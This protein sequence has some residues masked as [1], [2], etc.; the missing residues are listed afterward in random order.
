[1]VKIYGKKYKVCATPDT[2][3]LENTPV[4]RIRPKHTTTVWDIVEGKTYSTKQ[5]RSICRSLKMNRL[6]TREIKLSLVKKLSKCKGSSKKPYKDARKKKH[7]PFGNC[8]ICSNP[9]NCK[10]HLF[11]LQH[12][13]YAKEWN[14]INICDYCHAE[15][16]PWLPKP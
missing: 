15:V 11:Q 13:G 10:H 5:S 8:F 9:A 1:M 7:R 3:D 4:I 12:N 6:M 16:H 2:K 14:L